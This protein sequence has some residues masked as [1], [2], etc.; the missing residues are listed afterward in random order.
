[1]CH[2]VF[3]FSYELSGGDEHPPGDTSHVGSILVFLESWSVS[4]RERREVAPGLIVRYEEL[5]ELR[6][7][8]DVN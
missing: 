2:P 5:I 4:N 7:E 1:L 3:G 6:H 8:L